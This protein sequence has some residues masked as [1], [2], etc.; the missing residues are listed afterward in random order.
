MRTTLSFLNLAE[1]VLRITIKIV[2][3][4]VA[5]IVVFIAVIAHGR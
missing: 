3:V 4:F 5:T 1:T 2:L